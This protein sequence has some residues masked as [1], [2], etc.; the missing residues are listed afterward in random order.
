MLE[1]LAVVIRPGLEVTHIAMLSGSSVP[2]GHNRAIDNSSTLSLLV[3][4]SFIADR[5]ALSI[6]QFEDAFL[7]FPVATLSMMTST[8]LLRR[9]V[10]IPRLPT[11]GQ[12]Q[13]T[14]TTRRRRVNRACTAVSNPVDICFQPYLVSMEPMIWST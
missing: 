3:N 14:T 4:Q 5:Q 13:H 2:V 10:A 12:G 1:Q 7:L 6:P 11:T 8:P 9:T